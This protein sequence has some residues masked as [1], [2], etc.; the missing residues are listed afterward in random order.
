[1]VMKHPEFLYHGTDCKNVHSICEEGIRPGT[2]ETCNPYTVKTSTG[3]SFRDDCLDNVSM[4]KK[5]SDAIFF[6]VANRDTR[7]EM[8]QPQCIFKIWT[9]DLPKERLFYRDLFGKKNGEAKLFGRMGVPPEAI[10]GYHKRE[11]VHDEKGEMQVKDS[12]ESCAIER[13][14]GRRNE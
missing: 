4:A 5:E 13:S 8:F 14:R 11:F 7:E 3:Q 1:M 2:Y 9:N 6:I 12:W 10:A